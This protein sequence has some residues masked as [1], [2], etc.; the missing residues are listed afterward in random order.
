MK[1]QEAFLKVLVVEAIAHGRANLF[2]IVLYD[3][4]TDALYAAWEGWDLRIL[5]CFYKGSKP[6]YPPY[7][8]RKAWTEMELEMNTEMYNSLIRSFRI[9]ISW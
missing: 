3:A 1:E 6:K 7:V 4:F 2:D 8:F 9:E 5:Q